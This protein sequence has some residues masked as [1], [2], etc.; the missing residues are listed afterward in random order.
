MTVCVWV[1]KYEIFS[2]HPYSKLI[3]IVFSHFDNKF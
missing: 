1:C 2:L 3:F